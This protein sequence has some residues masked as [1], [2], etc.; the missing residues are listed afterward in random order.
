[1]VFKDTS[2]KQGLVEDAVYHIFGNSDDHT[3]E[4]PLADMA[5]HA[6]RWLDKVFA[7]ITRSDKKWEW[8]DTNQTDL[9]IA[10][11]DLVSNQQDY[12]ITA[13]EFLRIRKIDILE[14]NGSSRPL[15]LFTLEDLRGRA[16]AE[17]QKTAGTPLYGRIQASSLFLYPKPNYS[18]TNGIRIFYQRNMTYFVAGDT[19][20]KPGFAEPFHRIISL[21]MAY[22]YERTNG[23]KDKRDEAVKEIGE[24]KTELIDFYTLRRDTKNT[25]RP[26]RE[27]YGQINLARG[28]G[29]GGR[30][31]HPDQFN[32][33]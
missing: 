25:M 6:N 33:F 28:Q 26:M 14:S 13:A 4:Y 16:D 8:D 5:R 10:N 11:I 27:D 31:N 7:W 17:F 22:E 23:L 2:T 21:G 19:T 30:V 3:A 32:I 12:G 1:M 9:P 18:S 20:K 15:R 29:R 24:M